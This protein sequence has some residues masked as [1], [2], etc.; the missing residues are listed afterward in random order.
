MKIDAQLPLPENLQPNKVQGSGSSANPNR[1]GTVNANQDNA[2]LSVD[3]TSIEQLK[4]ALSQ[5]PEVRQDR[6]EALRQA[7]G[8]GSY[9]VTDQQLADAIHSE[10]VT[11][12]PPRTE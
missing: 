6:V 12:K 2:Q 10:L 11:G 5:V 3:S 4:A 7:V 8:N 9:Q 1:P